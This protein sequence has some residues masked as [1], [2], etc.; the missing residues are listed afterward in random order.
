[1][2]MCSTNSGLW[3]LYR[4]MG[5]GSST[6]K[7]SGKVRDG[8]RKLGVRTDLKDLVNIEKGQDSITVPRDVDLNDKIIRKSKKIIM[9]KV[10][11]VVTFRD[12]R[13]LRLG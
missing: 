1:M 13:G 4:G 3:N 9:I 8:G 5:Q 11:V 6:G 10:R 12:G 2:N 7:V